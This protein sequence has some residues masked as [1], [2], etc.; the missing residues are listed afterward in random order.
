[1]KFQGQEW[2]PQRKL[3][4]K[5]DKS[6]KVDGGGEARRRGSHSPEKKEGGKKPL[7]IEE[8]Y[9]EFMKSKMQKDKK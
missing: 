3:R 4:K 8:K 5:W 7:S 2:I 1:M 6:P 9:E